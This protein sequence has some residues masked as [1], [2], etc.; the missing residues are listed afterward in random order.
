[1]L[2]PACDC[3]LKLARSHLCLEF[4]FQ[5]RKFIINSKKNFDNNSLQT[6]KYALAVYQLMQYQNGKAVGLNKL[7]VLVVSAVNFSIKLKTIVLL[8]SMMFVSSQ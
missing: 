5:S 6:N 1:M 7:M 8:I 2:A 4:K 3:S